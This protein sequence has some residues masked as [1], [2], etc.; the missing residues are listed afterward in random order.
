M[1]VGCSKHDTINI[2]IILCQQNLTNVFSF[3]S[4]E[5]NAYKWDYIIMDHD[6]S[7]S[8]KHKNIHIYAYMLIN[9]NG[10]FLVVLCV[11]GHFFRK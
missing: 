10:L 11:E 6:K 8:T 1:G 3:E 7:S 5:N 2:K 9:G 4:Y